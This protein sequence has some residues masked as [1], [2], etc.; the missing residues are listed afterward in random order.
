MIDAPKK[1]QFDL[2]SIFEWI[3]AFAIIFA[4][5]E[6]AGQKGTSTS[7]FPSLPRNDSILL[8]WLEKQGRKDV[9]VMRESNSIMLEVKCGILHSILER[10]PTPPWQKLGYPLPLGIS[11]TTHSRLFNHSPY[12]WFIGFGILLLLRLFRSGRLHKDRGSGSKQRAN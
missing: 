10:L 8:S 6:D 1:L 11:I 3:A 9:K 4:L 2:F 5:M 12:I 7:V